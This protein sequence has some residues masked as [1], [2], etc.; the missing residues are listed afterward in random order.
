MEVFEKTGRDWMAVPK[1][2]PDTANYHAATGFAIAP[3]FIGY[4]SSN[5]LDFGDS[6]VSF[7]ESLALFGYPISTAQMEMDANGDEVLTQWFE[8]ARFEYR[9]GEVVPGALGAEL[10]GVPGVA[11]P[12]V[13]SMLAQVQRSVARFGDLEVAQAAGWGL[14]DGLD[15]CFTNP[16]V[17]DMGIHYINTDLLDTSLSP[18]TPEAMVYH[19]D[20]DGQLSLGAVEWIVPAEAWDAEGHDGPPEV[21]GHAFHLNEAL[22]V[23]VLHAW[24]FNENPAGVF[25]DWNPNVHCPTPEDDLDALREAV[26]GYQD[27]DAAIAD[28]YVLVE[29]LDHCF[30]NPGDGAMGVHYINTDLLDTEL[31][32]LQ[33]EAMVYQHDPG[34]ELSLGAVEWIVPAEPWDAEN[35]DELPMVMDHHLHPN[36]ALGVYV[37]HAWIFLENPAGLWEDW[38]PNV[39]CPNS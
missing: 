9:S 7:R 3:E 2:D 27:V 13:A 25:E 37:L 11:D 14:V 21:M 30:D 23:Y 19:H 31:D 10:L 20:E 33:P 16:G 29:G 36:E 4:W 39:S 12:S 26:A 35:P 15:H 18:L 5:G 38:N 34:G 8:R 28:G 24:I 32:P 1:E 6:D 17:G 22:G